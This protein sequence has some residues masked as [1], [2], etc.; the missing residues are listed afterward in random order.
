MDRYGP[1]N[2]EQCASLCPY[3]ARVK[4]FAWQKGLEWDAALAELEQRA[5]HMYHVPAASGQVRPEVC[6]QQG[7]L[8]D[9][10]RVWR[11]LLFVSGACGLSVYDYMKSP[12][13]AAL[14]DIEASPAPVQ[15]VQ[16]L[17]A[18]EQPIAQKRGGVATQ[19]EPVAC[20][21]VEDAQ[22]PSAPKPHAP[23]DQPDQPASVRARRKLPQWNLAWVQAGKEK[24]YAAW[25]M[26]RERAH[27][28]ALQ[29]RARQFVLAFGITALVIA[30]AAAIGVAYWLGYRA[31]VRENGTYE[32]G[33]QAA[34]EE[35][36]TYE[37]G[38][39][40]AVEENGTYDEGYDKGYAEGKVDGYEAGRSE[41]YEEGLNDGMT[42][43]RNTAE[44]ASDAQP[45]APAAEQTVWVSRYLGR[46]YHSTPDCSRVIDPQEIPL[47]QAEAEGYTPCNRC[48]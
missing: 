35:K 10:C 11:L 13:A 25:A 38:Y 27:M 17:P 24:L 43:S 14:F 48:Y 6:E 33:Y 19:A 30:V 47:S 29:G 7:A 32:N 45:Q 5:A 39:A 36:G 26:V 9:E 28:P 41:G 18:R 40:A 3:V 23:Q 15:P 21:Q 34:I 2:K 4:V 37:S 12:Q 20:A 1:Q 16:P 22:A 44:A 46:K 31:C 42:A 8:P